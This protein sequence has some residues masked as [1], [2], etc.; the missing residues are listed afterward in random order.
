MAKPQIIYAEITSKQL[1]QIE[2]S[3]ELQFC[4]P[5]GVT[6]ERKWGSKGFILKCDNED[7]SDVLVKGLNNTGVSWQAESYFLKPEEKEVKWYKAKGGF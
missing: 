7:V 2:V 5:R 1:N 6:M 4:F 3:G